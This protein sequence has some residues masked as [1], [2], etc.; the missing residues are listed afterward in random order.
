MES[1]SSVR[2]NWDKASLRGLIQDYYENH[3]DFGLV[4]DEPGVHFRRDT[5][6]FNSIQD[7][8]LAIHDRDSSKA[9]QLFAAHSRNP[10]VSLCLL[11]CGAKTNCSLV[12]FI[13]EEGKISII[14]VLSSRVYRNDHGE[15]ALHIAIENDRN[16][17]V[18]YLLANWALIPV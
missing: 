12:E 13:V 1:T 14:D 5:S 17:V 16:D 4:I 8:G 6:F 11:W 7:L 15:S 10:R 3:Q 2:Q 18:D 9:R